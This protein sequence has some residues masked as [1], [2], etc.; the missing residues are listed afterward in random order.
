MTVARMFAGIA[1]AIAG[2]ALLAACSIHRLPL[3]AWL[4]SMAVMAGGMWTALNTRED[5]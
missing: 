5:Q 3:L 4:G 1:T 2:V